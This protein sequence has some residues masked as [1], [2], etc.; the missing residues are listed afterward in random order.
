VREHAAPMTATLQGF[1]QVVDTRGLRWP[2][3]VASKV[4]SDTKLSN[5]I[6]TIPYINVNTPNII[7]VS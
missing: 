7:I 6:V 3:L 4:C 5:N 2:V 1:A